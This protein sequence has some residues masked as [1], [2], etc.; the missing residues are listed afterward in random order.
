MRNPAEIENIEELRRRQ[1]IDDDELRQEIER[2]EVG[3]TVKLTF[4]FG[5]NPPSAETLSVRITSMRGMA[6]RGK[7]ASKPDAIGLAKLR[8]GAT[9]VFSAADIHSIPREQAH[10]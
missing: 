2:L 8:L 3:D 9:I 5:R 6:F 1:G 7:L 4:L 10:K